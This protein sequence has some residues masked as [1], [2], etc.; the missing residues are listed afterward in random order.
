MTCHLRPIPGL[1]RLA[2]AGL[3]LLGGCSAQNSPVS[4]ATTPGP[5]SSTGEPEPAGPRSYPEYA[6]CRPLLDKLDSLPCGA[7]RA[8][9]LRELLR[10]LTRQTGIRFVIDEAS[11]KDEGLSVDEPLNLDAGP[12]LLAELLP[13]LDS[14]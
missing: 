8:C 2:L 10:D 4:P 13:E 9:P 3:L 1:P 14:H 7:R 5:T 6:A 11:L 12:P